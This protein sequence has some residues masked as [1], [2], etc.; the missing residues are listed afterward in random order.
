MAGKLAAAF[1]FKRGNALAQANQSSLGKPASEQ[2]GVW[3]LRRMAQ[4]VSIEPEANSPGPWWGNL[5]FGGAGWAYN[6]PHHPRGA[7]IGLKPL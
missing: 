4:T 3:S 6:G 2:K 7:D 5:I 1:L